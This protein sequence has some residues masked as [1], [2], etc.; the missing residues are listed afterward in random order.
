[1]A[2]GSDGTAIVSI[3]TN[4]VRVYLASAVVQ[5]TYADLVAAGTYA[6]VILQT[7]GQ[8]QVKG[9]GNA[10]VVTLPTNSA[11]VYIGLTRTL[12]SYGNLIQLYATYGGL[13]AHNY[14]QLG[15]IP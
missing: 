3:P 15:V 9:L 7:Y 10:A 12:A 11:N 6:A 1:M 14:S 2:A 8:W 5:G 4:A 13:A